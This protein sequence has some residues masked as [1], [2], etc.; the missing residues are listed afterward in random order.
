M[1]V[2]V[3]VCGGGGGGGGVSLNTLFTLQCQ[4]VCNR[5][6][7]PHGGKEGGV[8]YQVGVDGR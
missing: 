3:C 7:V 2:C 6:L 5:M 8:G 4:Q 1:C